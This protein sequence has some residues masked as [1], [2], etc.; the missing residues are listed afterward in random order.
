MTHCD[1]VE[2]SA[3]PRSMAGEA[4]A[5]IVW[6]TNIMATAKIIAASTRYLRSWLSIGVTPGGAS[7]GVGETLAPAPALERPDVGDERVEVGL[8]DDAAPVGHRDDRRLPD[9]APVL[10]HLHDLLGSVEL[11]P[12]VRARQ[13]RD[14]LVGRRRVRDAAEPV[15]AVAVDAAV[16]LV[17]H[18]AAR[19][20]ARARRDRLRLG[21]LHCGE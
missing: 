21:T 13:R 17:E 19:D 6:S 7:G 3:R 5:T 18:G 8:R 9:H 10:D 12:E 1:P 20:R 15:R 16:A 11:V 2:V 4:M 14:R